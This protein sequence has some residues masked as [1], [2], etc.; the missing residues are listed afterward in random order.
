[1]SISEIIEAAIQQATA[2]ETPE[3]RSLLW[4]DS[5]LHLIVVNLPLDIVY[6][7]PNS[8]RIKSQLTAHPDREA[9]HS[10][11]FS[12]SSQKSIADLLKATDGYEDLKINLQELGQ[13]EPGVITR[14]GVLINANTRAVALRALGATHL[15]T[16]VLPPGATTSQINELELRLQVARDYRQDYSFTNRLLLSK[17]CQEAG[18]TESRIGKEVF[19]TTGTDASRIEKV[20]R[21]LRLLAMIDELITVSG[22]KYTLPNFDDKFIAL[23]ELDRDYEELKKSD[24]T[25]ALELRAARQVA[26]LCGVGYREIRQ[27]RPGFVNDYLLEEIEEDSDIK[28]LA[29]KP[30]PPPE[31]DTT[32]LG[33][34]GD[35]EPASGQEAGPILNWLTQTAGQTLVQVPDGDKAPIERP[36][37][38]VIE[39]MQTAIEKAAESSKINSQR[40]NLLKQPTNLVIDAIKRLDAAEAAYK[41]VHTDHK[42]KGETPKLREKLGA[43]KRSVESITARLDANFP[44]G[45]GS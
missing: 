24:T 3:R 25:A 29:V 17:D 41:K 30:D 34:L 39:A 8:H 13:R 44:E 9:I 21:D 33:L 19:G 5:S 1:M 38:E 2:L 23:E 11:P 22:G 43:A 31:S 26:I 32:G 15:R 36:R 12:E 14:E 40:G 18:W 45:S 7:N 35:S 20:R 37:M 16:M 28:F 6:L 42:F 27:I 4:D 10:A